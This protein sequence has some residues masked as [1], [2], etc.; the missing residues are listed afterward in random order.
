MNTLTLGHGDIFNDPMNRLRVECFPEEG[1]V[2]S[3]RDEFDAVSTHVTCAAGGRLVGYLR[4][5]PATR[6][7]FRSR[8]GTEAALPDSRTSVDLGRACVHPDFRGRAL[9]EVLLLYGLVLAADVGYA[10]AVGSSRPERRL[11][12]LLHD[13][14]FHDSGPKVRA[15]Y[16]TQVVTQ[17]PAVVATAGRR[18]SWDYRLH[19]ILART[20]VATHA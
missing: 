1:W 16:N 11:R 15:T 8:L 9:F 4:L 6:G 17:L 18:E 14:G 3:A 19:A 10:F 7:Y 2:G 20:E 5:T 13:L 12:A